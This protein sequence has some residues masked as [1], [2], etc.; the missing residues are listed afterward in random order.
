MSDQLTVG[1][2]INFPRHDESN[3]IAA[4][5]GSIT[6]SQ[7]APGNFRVT[8]I[9]PDGTINLKIVQTE[10]EY[11]KSEEKAWR[12]RTDIGLSDRLD[13]LPADQKQS[14][15]AVQDSGWTPLGDHYFVLPLPPEDRLGALWLPTKRDRLM[16]DDAILDDQSTGLRKA[17]VV[18]VGPGAWLPGK[19]AF[20]RP[21]VGMAEVVLFDRFRGTAATVAGIE[22]L[23]IAECDIQAIVE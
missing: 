9:Q 6:L 11:R 18:G 19:T 4:N 20:V 10:E 16:G 14:L 21:S 8:D 15:L 2:I 7:G 13:V 3:V 22:V 1:D 23:V 5:T 12:F 17:L